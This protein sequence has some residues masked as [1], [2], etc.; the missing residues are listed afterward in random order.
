[1]TEKV[2]GIVQALQRIMRSGKAFGRGALHGA[3]GVGT[4]AKNLPGG[5]NHAMGEAEKTIKGLGTSGLRQSRAYGAGTLAAPIAAAGAPFGAAVGTV[6]ALTNDKNGEAYYEGF[7][8]ACQARGVDPKGLINAD[9]YPGNWVN[10][11]VPPKK[12]FPPAPM[13]GIETNKAVTVKSS[14]VHGMHDPKRVL[15]L[16][17]KVKGLLTHLDPARVGYPKGFKNPGFV[18]PERGL[19]YKPPLSFKPQ[20]ATSLTRGKAIKDWK[21]PQESVPDMADWFQSGN[22]NNRLNY[23]IEKGAQTKAAY[24][25]GFTQ[26]YLSARKE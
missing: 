7:V 18:M 26:Q 5:L 21:P 6:G 1:M 24:L 10:K 25:V 20:T 4:F 9:G 23:S 14:Q 16:I 15:T 3:R 17:E 22:I 19:A 2:A 8:K 12:L 11:R 13:P